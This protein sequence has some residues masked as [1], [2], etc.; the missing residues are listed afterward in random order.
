MTQDPRTNASTHTTHQP[1]PG[2]FA[3]TARLDA[4][5]PNEEDAERAPA[6]EEGN[7]HDLFEQWSHWSRTRRFYCPPPSTGTILGKLSSKTRPFTS[8]PP[9]AACNADLAALHLAILGQP[10]DALDTRVFQ[11]YYGDRA[12]FV[13]RSADALGISRQ[14][15]YRL[16]KSFCTRVHAVSQD[17]ASYNR[18]AGEALLHGKKDGSI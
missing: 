12:P 18:A 15:F 6:A 7:L 10:P 14:H 5:L 17:I 13:K 9:D 16:L 8:G 11:A 4:D 2:V 1:R 3:A